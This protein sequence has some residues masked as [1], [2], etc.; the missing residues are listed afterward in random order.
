[1]GIKREDFPILRIQAA[2]DTYMKELDVAL[3]PETLETY[4]I[5]KRG[6]RSLR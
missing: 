5:I 4:E 3:M 1:M 6:V 2:V